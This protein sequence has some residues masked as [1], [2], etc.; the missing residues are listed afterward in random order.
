M[1]VA[2]AL[3]ERWPSYATYVVSFLTIGIIWVNHHAVM[4][5]IRVVNRPLLFNNLL[6]L[7]RPRH[8]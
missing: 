7:I 6:F 8:Y 1:A 5:R 3:L 2:G 4:E